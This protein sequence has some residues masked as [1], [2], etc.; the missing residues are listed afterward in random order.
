MLP[1]PPADYV[2]SAPDQRL[3]SLCRSRNCSTGFLDHP[4]HA[5]EG[6]GD[7]QLFIEHLRPSVCQYSRINHSEL[8]C[9][10]HWPKPTTSD[11]ACQRAVQAC[12]GSMV[13]F[14]SVPA[15]GT[16]SV[17]VFLGVPWVLPPWTRRRWMPGMACRYHCCFHCRKEESLCV[18][19][20]HH[21]PCK[22]VFYTGPL[23][24]AGSVIK[25]GYY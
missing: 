8:M 2:F 16:S 15:L 6:E 10:Y 13:Q 12:C 23:S 3:K 14:Q 5:S 24:L 20:I 17:P 22:F 25:G 19:F 4:S 9:T 7:Q 18:L 21:D 1:Y 11:S